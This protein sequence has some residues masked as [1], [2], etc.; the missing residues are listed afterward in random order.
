MN[1]G[2]GGYVVV[3]DAILTPSVVVGKLPPDVWL[4]YVCV[5]WA[6]VWLKDEMVVVVDMWWW[7]MLF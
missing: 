4:I 2:G 5:V 7:W 6:R 1:V 3:V